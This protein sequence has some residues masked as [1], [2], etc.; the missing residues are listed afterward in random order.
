VNV[1]H[2]VPGSFGSL[3]G[4]ARRE[5]L[6][7]LAACEACRAELAGA[8]PESLF[9][10]L[11]LEPES[12]EILDAVSEGVARRM[13]D[14]R[15]SW[16]EALRERGLPPT[17]ARLAVAAAVAAGALLFLRVPPPKSPAVALVAPDRAGVTL[18][19]PAP[20]AHVIDLT[21]GGTQV[22]MIFDPELKL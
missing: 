8:E 6:R 4:D 18:V 7:H 1:A 9:A 3:S 17:G 11:A 2:V 10:L 15:P 16:I 13:V 21:V 22:V 5:A 12:P 14:A 20:E 19:E